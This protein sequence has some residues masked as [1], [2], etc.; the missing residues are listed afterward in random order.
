[1]TVSYVLRDPIPAR[2]PERVVYVVRWTWDGGEV[3][4]LYRSVSGATGRV[5]G[6]IGSNPGEWTRQGS[7]Y[8][9]RSPDRGTVVIEERAVYP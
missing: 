9:W 7:E 4:D 5:G 8:A 2:A 3:V 1:V 6:I